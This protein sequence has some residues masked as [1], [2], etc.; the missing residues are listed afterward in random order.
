[1][2]SE[3]LWKTSG[4]QFLYYSYWFTV[5]VLQFYIF[6]IIFRITV[7]SFRIKFFGSQFLYYIFLVH[8]F[9][10]T[11]GFC[12]TVSWFTVFLLRYFSITDVDLRFL[13]NPRVGFAL[14][15]RNV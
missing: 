12:I 15:F 2:V 3:K 8:T 10:I 5:F 6:Y 1:M 9:C 4:S 13:G 14:I 7:H 11:V